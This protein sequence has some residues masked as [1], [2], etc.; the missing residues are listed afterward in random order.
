MFLISPLL[1]TLFS[2]TTFAK[3]ILFQLSEK[4]ILYYFRFLVILE[5]KD[6]EIS[7]ADL[8]TEQ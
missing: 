7:S 1:K 6:R 8:L 3:V 2:K 5:K 4:A